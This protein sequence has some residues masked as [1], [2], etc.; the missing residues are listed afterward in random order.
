MG[1]NKYWQVST[2][3]SFLPQMVMGKQI[4]NQRILPQEKIKLCE[5]QNIF[6]WSVVNDNLE[7][8]IDCRLA[9]VRL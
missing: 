3:K 6:F 2:A 9:H 8:K 1:Y 5:K 4:I 7:V